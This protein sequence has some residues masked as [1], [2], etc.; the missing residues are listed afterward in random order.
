MAKTCMVLGQEVGEGGGIR[1][2]ARRTLRK[3]G[4]PNL[5]VDKERI[6]KPK[7]TPHL[8]KQPKRRQSETLTN[9]QLAGVFR[10]KV[11]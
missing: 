3:G 10:A 5:I 6:Q 7:S 11:N 2:G 9:A 4:T 8:C 1:E